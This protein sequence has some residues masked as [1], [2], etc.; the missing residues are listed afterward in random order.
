MRSYLITDPVQ[1]ALIT[2]LYI[3]KKYYYRF[4]YTLYLNYCLETATLF[5]TEKKQSYKIKIVN[6]KH[7]V[8]IIKIF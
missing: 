1:I 3:I 6:L 8:T 5:L 7:N 4:V 2:S